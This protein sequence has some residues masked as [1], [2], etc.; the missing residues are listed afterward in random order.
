MVTTQKLGNNCGVS[1]PGQNHRPCG[2][3]LLSRWVRRLECVQASPVNGDM[4]LKLWHFP[5]RQDV[6]PLSCVPL[7][8]C[9]VDDCCQEL[10]VLPCFCVNQLT[11]KHTFCCDAVDLKRSWLAVL[12][13]AATGKITANTLSSCD[14]PTSRSSCEINSDG[15]QECVHTGNKEELI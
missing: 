10:Q 5:C 12:K 3:T 7:L 6:K 1:S 15:A 8:G 2:C 9:E 4:Q 14:N 11:T 13:D